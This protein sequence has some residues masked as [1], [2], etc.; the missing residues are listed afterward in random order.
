MELVV[1]TGK[2][3]SGRVIVMFKDE[4]KLSQYGYTQQFY[5]VQS[6]SKGEYVT[7]NKKRYYIEIPKGEWRFPE[8]GGAAEWYPEGESL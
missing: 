7:V 5:K 8:G 1:L 3:R 6:N 4:T 2:D